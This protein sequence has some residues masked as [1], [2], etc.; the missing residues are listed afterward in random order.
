M[1]AAMIDI[2]VH[3]DYAR[4]FLTPGEACAFAVAMF[5]NVTQSRNAA[6]VY[7]SSQHADVTDT[8]RRLLGQI[9]EATERAGRPRKISSRWLRVLTDRTEGTGPGATVDVAEVRCG[10]DSS[11]YV[12]VAGDDRV[13]ARRL[14]LGH[15]VAYRT[16][17][18]VHAAWTTEARYHEHGTDLPEFHTRGALRVLE[19]AAYCREC[20]DGMYAEE[21]EGDLVLDD[22]VAM[23]G[24]RVADT[25]AA[26]IEGDVS[27]VGWD[28]ERWGWP[29][30]VRGVDPNDDII[31][32]SMPKVLVSRATVH[33][34]SWYEVGR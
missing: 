11:V 21:G 5:G 15:D 23:Y 22:M 8:V 27:Y 34:A 12:M 1:L 19:L 9:T 7:K 32:G 30:H 29:G 18:E 2:A 14:A 17:N 4:H 31:A 6:L 13:P 28:D 24:L 20:A 3:I 16:G 10:S 25:D 26:H 33:A